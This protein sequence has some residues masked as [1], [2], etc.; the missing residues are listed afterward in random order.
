LFFKK[1]KRQ[2]KYE[3]T[4]CIIDVLTTT[5]VAGFKAPNPNQN[6]ALADLNSLVNKQ[7]DMCVLCTFK[8]H[9]HTQKKKMT[10]QMLSYF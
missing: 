3:S 5:T 9:T 4:D 7:K 2:K 8:T 10:F 1:Y 6:A